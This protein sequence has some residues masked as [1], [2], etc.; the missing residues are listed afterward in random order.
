MAF[1]PPDSGTTLLMGPQ[2][3]IATLFEE[4]CDDWPRCVQEAAD[5]GIGA[6]KK[7]ELFELILA[8]CSAWIDPNNQNALD[9]LPELHFHLRGSAGS[10]QT[11]TLQFRGHDYIEMGAMDL[12]DTTSTL[13]TRKTLKAEPYTNFLARQDFATTTNTTVCVPAFGSMDYDTTT[14]GP[15]WILGTPLFYAFTV[16][17][18]LG[19]SPPAVQLST[20]TC[21]ACS[22]NLLEEGHTETR[23]RARMPRRIQGKARGPT[24]ELSGPF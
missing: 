16:S 21:T 10:S 15:V 19:A 18:D 4:I 3:H 14:N 7:A 12:N 17:Y 20:D 22:S 5:L 1:L 24:K 8:N 2:T 6:D 11:T 23:A 13:A 9:E